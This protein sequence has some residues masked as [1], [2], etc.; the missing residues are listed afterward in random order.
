MENQT[1]APKI[2]KDTKR[3]LRVDYEGKLT[4]KERMK[5]RLIPILLS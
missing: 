1:T 4:F 3:K 2:M 5:I